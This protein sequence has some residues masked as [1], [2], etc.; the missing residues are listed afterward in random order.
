M[1]EQ[2]SSLTWLWILLGVLGVIGG[3][4]VVCCGGCYFAMGRAQQGLVAGLEAGF[5]AIG[6]EFAKSPITASAMTEGDKNI[7]LQEIDRIY[8]A[9]KDNPVL[10]EKVGSVA[11][12]LANGPLVPAAVTRRARDQYVDASGLPADEKT[13]AT[14]AFNRAIRGVVEEKITMSDLNFTNREYA[15]EAKEVETTDTDPD[16]GEVT[17]DTEIHYI[18]K[19][20]IEDEQLTEYVE[21]LRTMADDNGVPDEDYNFDLAAEA[22]K[23]VDAKIA[24]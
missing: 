1:S 21:A 4:V 18:F 14:R 6:K 19:G 12:E 8:A 23:S 20:S 24:Q 9:S 22:K 10:K 16:T 2:K 15:I 5:E 11:G 13:A 3:G 17:T 7:M